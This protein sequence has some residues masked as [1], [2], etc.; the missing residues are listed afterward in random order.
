[1]KSLLLVQNKRLCCFSRG[2]PKRHV[3]VQSCLCM[4]VCVCCKLCANVTKLKAVKWE[5]IAEERRWFCCWG[6]GTHTPSLSLDFCSGDSISLPTSLFLFLSLFLCVVPTQQRPPPSAS[7]SI[8]PINETHLK[9]G[10]RAEVH[11]EKIPSACH[12]LFWGRPTDATLDG[13]AS[14]VVSAGDDREAVSRCL[15]INVE[16]R[17]LLQF[18]FYFTIRCE[19]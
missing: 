3:C 14:A 1:M 12:R 13:L 4:C 2:S 9:R 16:F 7:S 10:M 19:S 15:K 8:I 5:H 6:G 18:Y 11:D 17:H